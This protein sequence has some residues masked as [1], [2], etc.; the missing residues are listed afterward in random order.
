LVFINRRV[1]IILFILNCNPRVSRQG[2]ESPEISLGDSCDVIT[3]KDYE[4]ETNIF[5]IVGEI[6]IG[7]TGFSINCGEEEVKK[8]L[9]NEACNTNSD[10]ILIKE[11]KIP[12]SWSSCYRVNAVF[13][14]LKNKND[15]IPENIYGLKYDISEVKKYFNGVHVDS[16]SVPKPSF[17]L[18][19][20]LEVLKPAPA[21]DIYTYIYG[22]GLSY[23]YGFSN[24]TKD[25]N[26]TI[27]DVKD[28]HHLRICFPFASLE[29][30]IVFNPIYL[31]I[32]RSIINEKRNVQGFSGK[33]KILGTHY[34]IGIR[35]LTT[36]QKFWKLFGTYFEFGKSKWDYKDSIL[37]KNVTTLKYNYSNFYFSTGF[38]YYLK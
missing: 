27:V 20:G 6:K 31:G 19:I 35:F 7:D 38:C 18:A 2:Y 8:I 21:V 37:K 4:I 25:K 10:I 26:K 15:T 22:F 12:D 36:R 3:I 16:L 29:N 9:K 33:G 28:A 14:K 11:I 32:G 13:L 17:K 1:F 23:A 30:V 34:F 5:E 24:T